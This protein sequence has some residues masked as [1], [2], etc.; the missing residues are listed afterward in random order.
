M[1]ITHAEAHQLIQFDTDQSLNAQEEFTLRAHLQDCSECRA[2]TDEIKE[3]ENILVPVMK[4]HWHLTPLP[5]SIDA[6]HAKRSSKLQM[7]VIL[8]TRSMALGA[9]F[10]ALIFSAWQFGLSSGQKSDPMPVGVLPVPTPS[11]R[12]TSTKISAENCEGMFYA[13]R[14]NDT[15]ESIA[16]QFG[17]S[18]EKIMAAN[19]MKT[20]T[21]DPAMELVIPICS[22]TPTGTI[23]P[24][25]LAT[26]Y[27]PSM[28]PTTSTPDG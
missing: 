11:T 6:I 1:E 16:N 5:L 24:T 27:T 8:A 4:K 21:I 23:N 14:E 12:S 10:L 25:T 28:S 7:N 17:T 15:L 2:Y 22:F 19:R 20:E 26:S 13:V 9:V 18:K 3:V